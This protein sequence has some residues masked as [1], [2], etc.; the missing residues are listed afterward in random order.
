MP[1]F[2]NGV[3]SFDDKYPQGYGKT[4][5]SVNTTLFV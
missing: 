1:Y 2:M 4:G 5:Y 3:E